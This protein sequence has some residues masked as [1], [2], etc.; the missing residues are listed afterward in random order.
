MKEFA[1]NLNKIGWQRAIDERHL[2]EKTDGIPPLHGTQRLSRQIRQ[3]IL[4]CEDE[5]TLEFMDMGRGGKNLDCG[6]GGS[7]YRVAAVLGMQW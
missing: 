3:I 5:D 1:E 6:P 4:Q 2:L 7:G